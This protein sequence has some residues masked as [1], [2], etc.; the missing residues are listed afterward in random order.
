MKAKRG[1]LTRD[2]ALDAFNLVDLVNSKESLE[3]YN[4][5]LDSYEKMS[6]NT[7]IISLDKLLALVLLL[8]KDP[9]IDKVSYLFTIYQ[10][11]KIGSS[12]FMKRVHVRHMLDHLCFAVIYGIPNLAYHSIVPGFGAHTEKC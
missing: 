1:V 8:T 2:R 10:H 3:L 9:H 7:K 6:D 11:T 5:L 12:P 4:K